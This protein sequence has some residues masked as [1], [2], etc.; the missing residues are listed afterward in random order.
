MRS[1][2]LITEPRLTMKILR[3]LATTGA[4]GRSPPQALPAP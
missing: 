1:I 4:G 3:H 2:A